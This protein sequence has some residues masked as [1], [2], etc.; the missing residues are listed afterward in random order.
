MKEKGKFKDEQTVYHFHS[1]CQMCFKISPTL[2]KPLFHICGFLLFFFYLYSFNFSLME[3][4]DKHHVR[5]NIQKPVGGSMAFS[6]VFYRCISYLSTR[7]HFNAPIISLLCCTPILKTYNRVIL[8]SVC[9]DD[10]FVLIY[11][12]FNLQLL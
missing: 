7:P 9:T 5:K 3:P 8:L 1:I 6:L 11:L 4:D 12:P 2:L 10:S